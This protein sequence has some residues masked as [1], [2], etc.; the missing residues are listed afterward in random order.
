MKATATSM[1]NDENLPLKW[2]FFIKELLQNISKLLGSIG[3]LLLAM[4]LFFPVG[5][6][7]IGWKVWASFTKDNRKAR[8]ILTGTGKFFFSL[9]ISID[10][11]GNVMFGGMFNDL[12][13]TNRKEYPFGKPGQTISLVLGWND[14]LGNLNRLG[15]YVRQ[16]VDFFD[17]SRKGHC[18]YAML[19]SIARANVE[20]KKY[21]SSWINEESVENAKRFFEQ[22]K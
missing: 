8:Q 10:Q 15:R 22:Y 19:S 14:Y 21:R 9:A 3:L 6:L 16:T 1:V 4:V 2:R 7:A 13:L 5:I 12:L 20:V 11:L 18:E 17:F